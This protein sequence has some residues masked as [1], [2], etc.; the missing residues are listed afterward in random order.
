MIWLSRQRIWTVCILQLRSEMLLQ[1]AHHSL[2]LIC[3]SQ[4]QQLVRI[5]QIRVTFAIFALGGALTIDSIAFSSNTPVN[6]SLCIG[7]DSKIQGY[8]T[9]SQGYRIVDR[10]NEKL[11]T[12]F[13]WAGGFDGTNQMSQRCGELI[14]LHPKY[15][16]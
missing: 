13:A 14:R 10:V 6:A 8:A 5:C 16:F 9:T 7:G 1:I 2:H 12:T 4:I 3:I 15:Y 11:K